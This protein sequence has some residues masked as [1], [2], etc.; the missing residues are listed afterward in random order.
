MVAKYKS[1][2]RDKFKVAV[3]VD[4]KKYGTADDFNKKSAEQLASE[5]AMSVLG[6]AGGNGIAT[7]PP[8]DDE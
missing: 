1:E 6:V 7:V 5:R 3:F 8:D 2:K 4:G